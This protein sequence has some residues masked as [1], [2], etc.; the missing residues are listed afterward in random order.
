MANY[1]TLYEYTYKANTNMP[2]K[3]MNLL[4]KLINIY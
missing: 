1:I 3:Y 2:R 4:D